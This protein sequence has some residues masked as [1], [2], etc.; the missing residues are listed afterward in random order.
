VFSKRSQITAVMAACGLSLGAGAFAATAAAPPADATH[1]NW[2]TV[3]S[4]CYDCHNTE[5]WAGGVAFDSMSPDGIPQD[6]KIWE[7]AVRKLRGGMMPPPGHKRPD[8]AA[9]K[10]LVSYLETTLDDA[11]THTSPGRIPMQRL[12][13]R[14]Y[15][16]AVHDLIGLDVDGA[17]WLPQDPLKDGFDTNAELLQ[18]T[19]N[20]L[21]QSVA[22]ARAL[23]LEAVG[24][25]KAAPIDTT[26]GNIA[27]MIISLNPRPGVGTGNQE[28]YYD[29]MPFGTRGGM[30]AEH[31]FAADGEYSLT[32]G[33]MAMAR[34]VPKL[35]FE[36]TVIV[37]L[38]GKEIDRINVGGEND[39]KDVDQ[40]LDAGVYHI[41]TRLRDI[42]FHATAGQHKVAVTFL[43]RSYAESDE[44]VRPNTLDGGQQRVNAVH[45][46]Q[47]KGPI[48]ITGMS[49]TP[50]RKLIFI[51]RPAAAADEAP[52]AQKILANLAQHAFRRPVTDEDLK[53]LLAFYER[54]RQ[55]GTF[56]TGIRDA[57][58]AILASPN[59]LYRAEE[60]SDT[61]HTLDDVELASRMSFFIWSSIPD[62]ELLDLA[63]R[64]ELSKPEVLK[65]QVHRMLADPR[66]ISLTSDFAFQWL[67]I[68]KMDTISPAQAQFSYASGQYDPR[69]LFKKELT[70]FMDS[71]LRSDRSV[72]DLLTADHTYVNE[73]LALLYG[74]EN[75]K[76]G[77]FRRV[78]LKDP[79]RFGL[80]G[81]GAVLMTTANPDRTAP[82]LRGAWIMERILGTPQANP[83]LGVPT[84]I[85]T[86]AGK[87]TTVRERVE[88]HRRNPPCSGCH[89]VMDPLGFALENFDTVGQFRTVDPQSHQ[90]IDTDATMPDGTHMTGPADLHKAL[91]A[92]G[93]QFAQAITEK[94]M[95]YAVGRP[96]EYSDMPAVRNIAHEAASDN[97]RFESIVLGV[98]QSDAFRKRAPAAAPVPAS[99]TTQANNLSSAH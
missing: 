84:L 76:G 30:V 29:G 33:D 65:A 95:T 20:F 37:L 15:A 3:Q 19:P 85:A 28:K 78:T 93:P 23:A 26:Y 22:A 59:F 25:P 58:A 92:R 53:P 2:K 40:N 4:F 77:E 56:D 96:M 13:R 5:D 99:L 49:D 34:E 89:A 73:E 79:K 44:R 57:L 51:C 42:R 66:A 83:P 80:L 24:D 70:L 10:S 41:N 55:A 17:A 63:N 39:Y 87:P 11:A 32:I 90:A 75:V 35:E 88:V 86:V 67:N 1:G 36:N 8:P 45:A 43:R 31:W 74:M 12:N 48:K 68:A 71:I 72:V 69:P 82:V 52:C 64:N 94:L 98:V 7:Q 27:N 62:Q 6:A 81:K 97:F 60:A 50:S 16:N 14:E 91:A 21:D 46:M 9:V 18:V 54:G 61:V 47:I 38:D